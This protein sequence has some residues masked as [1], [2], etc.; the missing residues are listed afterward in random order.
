MRI[1]IDVDD[2]MA[3]CAVPYARAFAKEFGVE[4]G[5]GPLGWQTLDAYAHIPRER[6]DDFRQRIYGG[7][8]FAELACYPDVGDAVGR[9]ADNGHEIHFITARSERRRRITE[10]WL[11]RKS[12][13]R[14]AKT[15]Q[16]RPL[17]EYVP[18]SYDAYLSADYK[19]EIAR[20]LRLDAFCEDDPVIAERLAGDGVRVFLFDRPWNGELAGDG[21]ARV[22]DWSE[23]VREL[24][25]A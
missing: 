2:V 20:R 13:F 8:F 5:D 11:K 17:G 12:L 21:I 15:V 10:E 14:Y 18:R 24:V 9:L 22:R 7:T 16:L 4:L 19:V 1:G 25:D 6:R 3:E 23:V